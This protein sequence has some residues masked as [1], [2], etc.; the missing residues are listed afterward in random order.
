MSA[1]KKM[2][3][4]MG[5]LLAGPLGS[6]VS[7]Q[8]GIPA[9]QQNSMP[10]TQPGDEKVKATYYLSPRTVDALDEAKLKLRRLLPKSKRQI[11]TSAIVDAAIQLII[12]DLDVEGEKSQLA[13]LL[14]NQ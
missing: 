8:T 7:Q 13:S 3:D 9:K 6:P 1:R 2:P 10:V 12:T 14:V 11:S 5:Q 4:V